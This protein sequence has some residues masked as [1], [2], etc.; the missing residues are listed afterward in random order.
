MKST[1][2][3]RLR[4]Q[5][6]TKGWRQIDLQEYSGVYWSLIGSYEQGVKEPA[7]RNLIRLADALGTSIDYLVGREGSANVR[8]KKLLIRFKPTD[9]V[10]VRVE[11][12]LPDDQVHEHWRN[13]LFLNYDR[14]GNACVLFSN[15]SKEVIDARKLNSELRKPEFE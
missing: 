7:V 14:N 1:F 9:F 5:R 6:L 11:V 8:D 12:P 13:A 10:Q 2:A 15:G 3:K 4:E